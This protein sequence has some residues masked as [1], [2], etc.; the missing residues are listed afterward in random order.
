MLL[1]SHAATAAKAVLCGPFTPE[2]VADSL[3]RLRARG[4]KTK[5]IVELADKLVAAFGEGKRPRIKEVTHFLKASAFFRRLFKAL[6]PPKTKVVMQPASGPPRHWNLPEL[7]TLPGLAEWLRLDVET[8]RWLSSAWRGDAEKEGRLRHYHYRWIPRRASLPRLIEAP[9]PGLKVVQQRILS[10][11]LEHIP[12]HPAAHGFVKGRGIKSFTAPHT[13]QRCVLRMD[14]RNFFPAIRRALVLRVF[15]TAGYPEAIA[16]ALADL[17][18]TVTPAAVCGAGFENL[19]PDTAWSFRKHLRSRHLPQGA[20]TSP[21]LAN[22]CAFRMD[23]R[24][25]GLARKFGADYTRYADDLL[26]SGGEDFRRDAARCQARAGAVL[27][28]LGFA[29]AQ[30]KTRLMPSSV[31]QR[32]AGLVLN[33][34]AALPRVERDAL[35]AILTN[36]VRHGPVSQNRG[37]HPDFQA[38]LRGR[39]S[40]AAHVHPAGAA[41]LKS[42][43][44]AIDW[45]PA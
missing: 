13:G 25:K 16:A 2:E 34:H 12:A 40:H 7:T 42:L 39:I 19:P 26:F 32:A 15:L 44:G 1:K 33:E 10:G 43:F 27:L 9:L 18:T 3:A 29:I 23:A 4:R 35:K 11:I 31:S 41:K 17:C 28:E 21:A 14:I 36:C 37:A 8:L 38:H 45:D 24:L 6:I 5:E 22:L 20:P 30:R